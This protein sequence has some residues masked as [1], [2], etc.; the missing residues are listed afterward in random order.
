MQ[1][2]AGAPGNTKSVGAVAVTFYSATAQSSLT[3]M[4]AAPRRASLDLDLETGDWM[5]TTQVIVSTNLA[6]TK[7]EAPGLLEVSVPPLVRDMTLL[8]HGVSK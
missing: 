7:S 6:T 4:L 8:G 2:A 1:E 5:E 3:R